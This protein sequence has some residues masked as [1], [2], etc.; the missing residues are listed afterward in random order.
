MRL[1]RGHISIKVQYEYVWA[2]GVV[3]ISLIFARVINLKKS[4]TVFSNLVILDGFLSLYSYGRRSSDKT[5]SRFRNKKSHLRRTTPNSKK[6]PTHRL[7]YIFFIYSHIQ[8][9]VCMCAG[10]ERSRLPIF[11]RIVY[12]R[13][14]LSLHNMQSM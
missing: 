3:Y 10:R 11:I 2:R 4:I 1:M 14:E 5:M 9:S 6:M 13:R 8:N 7:I 12:Y